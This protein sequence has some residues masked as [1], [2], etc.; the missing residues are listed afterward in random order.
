[1]CKGP[2]EFID[3]L[4]INKGKSAGSDDLSHRNVLQKGAGFNCCRVYR[5]YPKNCKG[6][7]LDKILAIISSLF[8]F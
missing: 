8:L 2:Y 4:S 5:N 1:M 7:I 6:L 3:R